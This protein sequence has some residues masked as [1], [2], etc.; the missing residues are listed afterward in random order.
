M[1]KFF[2]GFLTCALLMISYTVSAEAINSFLGKQVEGSF[3]LIVNNNQST[4]D[5]LVIDGTAFVPVRA[6]GTLLGFTVDFADSKIILNTLKKEGDKMQLGSDTKA[7]EVKPTNDKFTIVNRTVYVNN[8]AVQISSEILLSEG[9]VYAY[10]D[11]AA[12]IAGINFSNDNG[13]YSYKNDKRSLIIA[14]KTFTISGNRTNDY[15]PITYNGKK[16]VPLRVVLEPLDIMMTEKDDGI[17][18][19]R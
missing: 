17:Y 18:I 6:S 3:P 1:R 13:V 14:E 4:V 11:D 15:T 16:Y 10:I 12:L 5:A 9:K 8:T 19:T 7:P 2:I